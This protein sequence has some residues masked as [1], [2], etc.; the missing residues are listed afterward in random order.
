VSQ[1][2]FLISLNKCL[3]LV[4]N[5]KCEK[6]KILLSC[7]KNA[8][9]VLNLVWC[10]SLLLTPSITTAHFIITTVF[11]P[12]PLH[13]KPSISLVP[14]FHISKHYHFL[15]FSLSHIICS[16]FPLLLS[17]NPFTPFSYPFPYHLKKI[18]KSHIPNMSSDC[19]TFW[20]HLTETPLFPTFPYSS[21]SLISLWHTFG[22]WGQ[23]HQV[24]ISIF[25]SAKHTLFIHIATSWQ[26]PTH[27]MNKTVIP[28]LNC[29]H[30]E[31]TETSEKAGS[32]L[33]IGLSF[34]G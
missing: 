12:I 3:V 2:H 7:F 21:Q 32:T 4:W 23:R 22:T 26:T 17:L 33:N 15:P 29:M 25:Q 30:Q 13:P 6:L 9:R 8:P 19:P 11:F 27:H 28:P 1:S 14:I 16:K 24:L 20:I 5:F 31:G 18:S 34:L 10:Q